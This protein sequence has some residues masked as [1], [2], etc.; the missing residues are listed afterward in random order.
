MGKINQLGD[1][2]EVMALCSLDER[3]IPCI[4]FG[5][6]NARTMGGMNSK[7]AFMN[8]LDTIEN[9]LGAE[10]RKHFHVHFQK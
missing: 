7:E 3:L 4:D 9:V 6:L 5:H 10:R 1:L 8:V 2:N